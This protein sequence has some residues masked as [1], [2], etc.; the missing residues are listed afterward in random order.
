MSPPHLYSIVI[1]IINIT[2]FTILAYYLCDQDTAE[3]TVLLKSHGALKMINVS[4]VILN[5]P[6]RLRGQGS[7]INPKPDRI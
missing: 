6:R 5:F 1:N 4:L 3:A 2:V 7:V